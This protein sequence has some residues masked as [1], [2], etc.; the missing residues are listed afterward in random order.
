MVDSQPPSFRPLRAGKQ[1]RGKQTG[2]AGL[3]M[4]NP[5]KL[6]F[7]ASMLENPKSTQRIEKRTWQ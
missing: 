2:P 7:H 3:P 1:R 6:R 5:G 4:D